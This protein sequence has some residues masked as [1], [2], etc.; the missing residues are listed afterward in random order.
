[1]GKF[2]NPVIPQMMSGCFRETTLLLVS[3]QPA[4][5]GRVFPNLWSDAFDV[6]R[7]ALLER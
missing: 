6:G 2:R 1:M 4:V 3:G 5:D 7:G